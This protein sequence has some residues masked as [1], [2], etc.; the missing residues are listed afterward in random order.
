MHV[1]VVPHACTC[2]IVLSC[3][4][5]EADC[6]CIGNDITSVEAVRSTLKNQFDRNVV[7]NF[8]YQEQILDHTFSHLGLGADTSVPHAVVMTEPVCNPVY[9]R[10][11]SCSS[12][13]PHSV[14]SQLLLV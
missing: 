5:G 7:T 11:G 10:Y 6:V 14:T 13:A 8:S 9:S 12:S 4:Q 1:H 3:M 2:T